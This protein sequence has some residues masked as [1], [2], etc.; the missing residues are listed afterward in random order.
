M[1][2]ASAAGEPRGGAVGVALVG[3]SGHA[4]RVVAPTIAASEEARLVGVL[5]SSVERG[6][7]LA[8]G[9]PGS[10]A[11]G[12]WAELEDDRAVEVVWIAGPNNR[13]VEFA[14][15]CLNA[16]KN[17]LLEKPMAVSS[18]EAERLCALAEKREMLLRVGFQHRFRPGHRWLREALGEGLVGEP[19]LMRIHR[20]WPFPYFRDMSEDASESWRSS[21]V[22]SGGWVLNDIGAHLIDLALWLLDTRED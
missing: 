17:V 5:G 11:Y 16:G 20:F 9:H 3:P 19:R 10:R 7:E 4:A 13:H 21:L 2:G 1:T 6:A 22:E 14:E 15:R 8:A 18:A 12:D